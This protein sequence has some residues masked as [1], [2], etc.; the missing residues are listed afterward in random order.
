[1]SVT[2][3]V[4]HQVFC[5][6]N[7]L[8]WKLKWTFKK[9]SIILINRRCWTLY[10]IKYYNNNFSL[11]SQRNKS[12]SIY[13]VDYH[14]F[15]GIEKISTKLF[16]QDSF[17][18]Q[19]PKSRDSIKWVCVFGCES[20]CIWLWEW[21]PFLSHKMSVIKKVNKLFLITFYGNSLKKIDPCPE[22]N[23][24]IKNKCVSLLQNKLHD[25]RT[26]EGEI[27]FYTLFFLHTLFST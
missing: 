20:L 17:T 18:K 15:T 22:Y 7:K 14:M 10:I 1:M 11:F 12:I 3:Q 23:S 19:K 25:R 27:L 9:C 21:A 4:F 13:F 2:S 24:E 16:L 5:L 8:G 26:F 6:R